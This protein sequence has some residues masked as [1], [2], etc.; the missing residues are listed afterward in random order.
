MLKAG[1]SR[2]TQG[3]AVYKVFLIMIIIAAGFTNLYAQSG[4]VDIIIKQPPPNQLGVGDMWNLELNNTSGKDIKIYL[5]GTATEEKD[6]LIIEGKS[7][8]FTL[9]PGRSNFK[10]NDFSSAEVK[11]N[12][13]KYKEIILR[14]GNAPE[15]RYTICVTAFDESSTEVGRENCIIQSVVRM[16]N[17][18]LLTPGDGEEIEP[19][20][21]TVFTWT[22]LPGAKEYTLKMY[23]PRGKEDEDMDLDLH[24]PLFEKTGITTTTFQYPLT[25][26]KLEEGK[27]YAW[28]VSSG[29]VQS[30]VG[31]FVKEDIIWDTDKPKRKKIDILLELVQ[32]QKTVM[33]TESD[34][35]GNFR[36]SNIPN[37]EYN[38]RITNRIQEGAEYLLKIGDISTVI[39][40]SLDHLCNRTLTIS[41]GGIYSRNE[42]VLVLESGDISAMACPCC[43]CCPPYCEPGDDGYKP[44]K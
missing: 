22:P 18:T 2:Y 4:K 34:S 8:V 15:G 20:K 42:N 41:V 31:L 11:Y 12:N 10:Y 38:L 37:G 19:Q 30:E 16:G 13:G 28:Q 27:K 29:D 24:K 7:K 36:F 21:P 1:K 44:K 23:G 40:G 17:I 35:V 33:K 3:K 32:N 14:T 9:K 26:P 5:T 39:C 43:V 25:A 6:G